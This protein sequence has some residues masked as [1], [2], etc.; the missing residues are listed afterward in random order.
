MFKQEKAERDLPTAE[1]LTLSEFPGNLDK[2]WILGFE[3]EAQ[4][5]APNDQIRSLKGVP[6]EP[7]LSDYAEGPKEASGPVRGRLVR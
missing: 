2:S 6:A 3:D 5:G 1:A 7:L 4:T